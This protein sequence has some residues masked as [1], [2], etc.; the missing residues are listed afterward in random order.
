VGGGDGEGFEALRR[1]CGENGAR[2]LT[3]RESL[4]E[5]ESRTR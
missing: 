4:L 5:L 2:R 1:G 3:I